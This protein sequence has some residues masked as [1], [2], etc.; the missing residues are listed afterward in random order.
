ML[1]GM[2]E[3]AIFH[4]VDLGR[5]GGRRRRRGRSRRGGRGRDTGAGREEAGAAGWPDRCP[6]WAW[7]VHPT[8][9]GGHGG[10][11]CGQH[12]GSHNLSSHLRCPRFS[13]VFRVEPVGSR[14]F[15]ARRWKCASP[16][17]PLWTNLGSR[18]SNATYP[19]CGFSRKSSVSMVRSSHRRRPGRPCQAAALVW[20]C[21]TRG[22]T[23]PKATASPAGAGHPLAVIGGALVVVGGALAWVRFDRIHAR[24]GIPAGLW[25]LAPWQFVLVRAFGPPGRRFRSP[26]G[27]QASVPAPDEVESGGIRRS[28]FHGDESRAAPRF[29]AHAAVTSS[30][31]RRSWWGMRAGSPSSG[32]ASKIGCSGARGERIDSICAQGFSDQELVMMGYYRDARTFSPSGYRGPFVEARRESSP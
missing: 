32:G 24:P 13:Q 14:V 29:F 6:N 22:R 25:S 20:S 9:C 27:A 30:S 31:W 16:L 8:N 21:T 5:L 12:Q 17:A 26:E 11:E 23:R 19:N 28:L 7:A 4:D 3:L 2:L 15:E 10:D 18:S 1:P